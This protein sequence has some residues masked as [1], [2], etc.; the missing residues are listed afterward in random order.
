MVKSKILI[1]D[2]HEIVCQGLHTMLEREPKFKIVGEAR[3][4]VEAVRAAKKLQPNVVIMD[5]RMPKMDGV[6]ACQ[7]IRQSCPQTAV[8][9]LSVYESE[10]E[11][12]S[13]IEAGASGYMLKDS[14]PQDLVSAIE[15]VGE[16]QFFFH[17]SVA[18]KLANG[19]CKLRK[20]QKITVELAEKLTE[21]EIE[22]LKLLSKGLSNREIAEKLYISESTVKT[23]VTHI[24]RKL[25]QSDRIHALL[26]A[27]KLGLTERSSPTKE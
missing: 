1:A 24:L 9:M 8:L 10:A 22:I 5:V 14:S 4:G 2:D 17:P 19:F 21:R 27:Q 15:A 11:I 18:R 7:E 26:Y 13:S 6:N 16:G 23:H 12:Y 20:T 3:D 25:N